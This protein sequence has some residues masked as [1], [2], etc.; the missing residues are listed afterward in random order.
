MNTAITFTRKTIQLRPP[1]IRQADQLGHLVEALTRGIV[2]CA[3][4]NTMLHRCRDMNEHR[5]AAADNQRNV[6]FKRFQL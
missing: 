4:K 2:H 1:G 6:W 3:T 5:V